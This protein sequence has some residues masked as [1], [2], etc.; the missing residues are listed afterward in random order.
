MPRLETY[1]RLRTW[2]A[3]FESFENIKIDQVHDNVHL[4]NT[5]IKSDLMLIKEYASSKYLLSNI[6]K[7]LHEE[8]EQVQYFKEGTHY[9]FIDYIHDIALLIRE[10]ENL[11]NFKKSF[12]HNIFSHLG[13]FNQFL[14][15]IMLSRFYTVRNIEHAMRS[16]K[17]G[18]KFDCDVE[19]EFNSKVIHCQIK[20]VA[21]HERQD[22]LHDVKDSI[23]SGMDYPQGYGAP[24]RKMAYKIV[25]FSGN[26]PKQMPL[27]KW[28]EI[29]ASLN[30]KKR[31]FEHVI[32]K[33]TYGRHEKKV[34]KFKIHGFRRGAFRYAPR[35]DFSNMRKL[36]DT[37]NEIEE[38][39]NNTQHSSDDN[40]MLI[41]N[42]YDHPAWDSPNIKEIRN[43]NLSIMTVRIWGHS[44]I[45]FV[46]LTTTKEMIDLERD[47]KLRVKRNWIKII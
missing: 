46:T 14:I 31:E 37:Y 7:D 10:G 24:R 29:G 18:A 28:T 27:E 41:T 43:S 19:I 17:P 25:H 30:I 35:D 11:P 21:E 36:I 15:T 33:D 5:I 9:S 42:S 47:F 4:T 40:F 23:E 16:K 44:M 34:I 45:D 38:R 32:P 39:I 22:R 6:R 1:Y 20:D 26:P 12:K 3:I 8:I 2:D 13:W